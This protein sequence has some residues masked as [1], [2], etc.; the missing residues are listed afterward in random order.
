MSSKSI[1]MLSAAIAASFLILLMPAAHADAT[2]EQNA[3]SILH[4]LD[5]LGVDY[6]GSVWFGKVV[7]EREYQ[8]QAE[9]AGQSAKLLAKLPSHPNQAALVNEAQELDRNVRAKAPAEQVSAAAQQLRRKIIAAYKVPVSPR[10]V[11]DFKQA[12][13]LYQQLCVACHG[14]E[15][16]GDGFKSETLNPRPTNFHDAIRMGKRS[17]YGLYNTISLGVARTDMPGFSQ[18]SD[19]ER[20]SLAFLVSNFHNLPERMDLGH[21]LWEKRNFQGAAPNLAALATLTA[22]EVSI[23]HGDNTRAV[24]EY[25]R[26]EPQALVATRHATLIFAAEQ[27]DQA[28][29]RYRAGDQT[30]ALHFAIEA[31]LEGFEPMEM[32]LINLNAQLRVD[33]EREMMTIR[34]LIYSG[35]PI[36][37]LTMKIEQAKELLS[38]ADELLRGGKLTITGAFAS[39]L[40]ILLHKGWVVLLILPTILAFVARSE[41]RSGALTYIHAGWGSALLLGLFTWAAT[42][43]FVSISGSARTI[44][45]GVTALLASAIL[46]YV[47]LLLHDKT[48][49]RAWQQFLRDKVGTVLERKTLRVLALISFFIVY[50]EIFEAVLFYQS[51]WTQTSHVIRTSLWGGIFAGG[52][53]L[54]AGGWGLFRFVIKLSPGVFFAGTSI[55]FAFMAVIFVG[56]SIT[57]LQVAGIVAS[58]PINLISLPMLG[59]LPT[60]QSLLAQAVVVGIL[61][62]CYRLPIW[63]RRNDRNDK[64]PPAT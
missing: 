11:P 64:Y 37:T 8:E 9:F 12:A 41:R 36:E 32:G 21:K 61:I 63:H 27:L 39:S 54:L 56:Q 6:G 13:I 47:W 16:H 17:V 25:L 60:T 23:N 34:Q 1:R 59:L 22:N 57:S 50:R 24:F 14:A 35:V 38:Q 52:L 19:E 26:A 45:S 53:T 29:A 10:K 55:L 42:T 15:G 33:I 40:F 48:H 46:I 49:T 44:I 28:L 3:Q 5:Y 62:L 43:W 30:E 20:W 58:N 7:N 4:M 18:L 31:Y 51:L 2:S